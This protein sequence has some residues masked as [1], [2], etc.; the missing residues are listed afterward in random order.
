MG[1]T[2]VRIVAG[3][4]EELY[5]RNVIAR[6]EATK[7]SHENVIARSEATKQSKALCFV[8][9]QHGFELRGIAV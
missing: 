6:S 5:T 2:E 8:T 7:Q 9:D 1:N 4:A 3:K